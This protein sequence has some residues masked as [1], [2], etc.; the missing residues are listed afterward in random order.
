MAKVEEKPEV[1]KAGGV[2]YTPGYIV[3]YIVQNT[4]GKWCEGKTPREV[5]ALK[6][7]DPA[8]GSGSFLLGAYKFLLDWHLKWYIWEATRLASQ[9]GVN[10]SHSTPLGEYVSS[11]HSD[12]R[13]VASQKGGKKSIQP[14][15]PIIQTSSGGWALTLAE[16][17]RILLNNIYGVD[18][19]AQAVEVAKLS[20]SLAVLEGATNEQLEGNLRLFFDRALPNLSSNIKC[21]NSLISSDF[22][23]D[24]PLDDFTVDEQ[25]R[26]NAFDWSDPTYGFG[27]I[28][29]AGGFDIVIGNP[30]YSYM[31]DDKSQNYFQKTYK[32]QNYQKDLYLLFLEKYHHLLKKSGALGVIVPN[33]WLSSL[34]YQA[35][36]K[37]LSSAYTWKRFLY[38]PEYV[39][40]AVVDTIVLIFEKGENTQE[41]AFDVDVYRK[42]ENSLSLL[43]T[44][45]SSDI[46][47]DGTPINIISN[48]KKQAL[49]NRIVATCS[50][51]NT[52]C[53]I[54]NGVKPFEK[55]KGTP[56]QTEKTMHEKPFVKEGE[57]PDENWSPLMR[58]SLIQRYMNLWKNNYWILYGPWLAAPRNSEIFDAPEKIVVRQTGDSLIATIIEGGIIARDNLHIILNQAVYNLL[59]YLGLINSRFM[60]FI[61]EIMNPEKGEALAQVKKKHV[62]LLPIRTI[63]FSNSSDVAQHDALAKKVEELISLHA[64][65][66]VLPMGREQELLARR[67]STLDRQIDTLVYTLYG[68]TPEEIALI[69]S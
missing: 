18:L 49:Y 11:P 58:G 55:G 38:L 42:K 29:T 16:K 14:P 1:K 10:L 67:A 68:L 51:L 63:D 56:P 7:L 28:L 43:H 52:L 60:N 2:F 20:L 48:P 6:I 40:K 41:Y 61:Y 32:H 15:P 47:T 23:D 30:P 31:I 26:I 3:D 8:C 50:Q 46:P 37:H 17:K 33:T 45:N 57:K 12:A 19:D 65:I 66:R 25:L 59:N 22:Y 5:S 39:F 54:C 34:T 62:E 44:L 53:K 4:V 24:N 69:E 27:D 9:Q 35:I 64:Q 36:R 21:G 13:R